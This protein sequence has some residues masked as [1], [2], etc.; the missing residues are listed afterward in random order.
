MAI[1]TYISTPPYTLK[2]DY[3]I[4]LLCAWAWYRYLFTAYKIVLLERNQL[5]FYSILKKTKIDPQN[6]IWI[7][8]TI[9]FI[10]IKHVK[11]KV[12]TSTLMNGVPEFKSMLTTLNSNIK[13]RYAIYRG[14]E[15]K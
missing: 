4:I 12:Y 6:I 8:E 11:G 5:I 13:I 2:R 14:G 15:W 10:I 9:G 7:K 3:F 1:I